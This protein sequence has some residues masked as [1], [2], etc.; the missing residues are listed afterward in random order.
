MACH[1]GDPDLKVDI[2]E[3][4]VEYMKGKYEDTTVKKLINIATCLDPRFMLNYCTEE[5]A[6]FVQQRVVEEGKLIAR[7][8]EEDIPASLTQSSESTEPSQHLD[9]HPPSKKRKLVDILTKVSTSR[10]EIL[11]NKDRIQN[12]LTRYLQCPQPEVKSNPLQWWKSHHTN[13]PV[14]S[15]LVKKYLSACATSSPL[16]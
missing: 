15:Q 9:P 11:D 14:L 6:T 5:E 1:E 13:F 8:L 2:Q 16:E 3:K 10:N 4:I 7:R 12:E